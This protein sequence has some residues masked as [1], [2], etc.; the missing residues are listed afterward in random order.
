MRSTILQKYPDIHEEAVDGVIPEAT[1]SL[2]STA[3]IEDY[4]D[5][6]L[7]ER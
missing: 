3:D 7:K 2:T 5:R 4:V 1:R 6:V